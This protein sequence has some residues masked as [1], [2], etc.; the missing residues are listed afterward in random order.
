MNASDPTP[1]EPS[2]DH[3][4]ALGKPVHIKHCTNWR[5]VQLSES[6]NEEARRSAMIARTRCPICYN[7]TMS[8]SFIQGMGEEVLADGASR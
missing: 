5:T 1:I 2:V 8:C 7:R 4:H 3:V 6:F